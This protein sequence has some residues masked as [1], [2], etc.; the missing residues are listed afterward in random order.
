MLDDQGHDELVPDPQV[1][2]E[3]ATTTMQLWRWDKDPEMAARGWPPPI[4]IK[5]RKFRSRKQLEKFKARLLR[6]ALSQRRA[7]LGAGDA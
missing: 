6:E 4:R 1:W 7:K 5:R 2:R 3:L